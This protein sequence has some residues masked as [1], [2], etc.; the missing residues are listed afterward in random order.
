MLFIEYLKS[1]RAFDFTDDDLRKAYSH[2]KSLADKLGIKNYERALSFCVLNFNSNDNPFIQPTRAK[3]MGRG[4][5]YLDITG[6]LQFSVSDG[7]IALPLGFFGDQLKELDRLELESPRR[8]KPALGSVALFHKGNL[9]PVIDDQGKPQSGLKENNWKDA[10]E[11]LFN[12]YGPKRLMS[13]YPKLS[14][15]AFR[16]SLLIH[17]RRTTIGMRVPYCST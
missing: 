14:V 1:L 5:V 17:W 3:L 13:W 15:F 6:R 9:S 11:S 16:K 12:F 2:C 10:H 4:E 7:R 8:F